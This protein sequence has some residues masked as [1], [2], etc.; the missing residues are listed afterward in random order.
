MT[1][2]NKLPLLLYI[3]VIVCYYRNINV[4]GIVISSTFF[5]DFLSIILEIS[6]IFSTFVHKKQ[7]GKEVCQ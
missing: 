1:N 2:S 6:E 5:S 4:D 7:V 3:K